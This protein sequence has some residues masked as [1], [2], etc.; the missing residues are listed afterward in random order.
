MAKRRF[1]LFLN[2]IQC[3]D[4]GLFCKI[5][6]T[7][8]HVCWWI[9]QRVQPNQARSG[10]LAVVWM[11]GCYTDI[12]VQKCVTTARIVAWLM[13]WCCID[14]GVRGFWCDTWV[15]F[16]FLFFFIGQNW[17]LV[18]TG[19]QFLI[20]LTVTVNHWPSLPGTHLSF[21]HYFML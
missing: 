4:A 1:K 6:S 15:D 7:R 8:E 19:N 13:T 3:D 17:P 11:H 21:I 2:R 12:G 5:Q 14:I 20:G 16:L 18:L 9:S 10:R